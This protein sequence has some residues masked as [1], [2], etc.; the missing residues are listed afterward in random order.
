MMKSPIILKMQKTTSKSQKAA[1][2]VT[3][4]WAARARRKGETPGML[5]AP[6]QQPVWVPPKPEPVRAGS[7]D[8]QKLPS[9][10]TGGDRIYR[11]HHV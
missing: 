6:M 5:I 8:A 9:L 1:L 2:S 4:A 10:M 3:G 11:R 7:Q